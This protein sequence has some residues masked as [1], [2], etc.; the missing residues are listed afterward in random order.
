MYGRWAA[1]AFLHLTTR[2]LRHPILFLFLIGAICA[3]R[4]YPASAGERPRIVKNIYFTSW[5][6]VRCNYFSYVDKDGKP[7]VRG[8]TT[9][10]G[11]G[12]ASILRV[13]SGSS[14]ASLSI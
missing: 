5:Q 13:A 1:L 7:L 10:L 2:S 3:F 11:R 4:G 9:T 6:Y 14:L 12:S 8:A